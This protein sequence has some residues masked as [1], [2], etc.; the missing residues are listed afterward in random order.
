[1]LLAKPAGYLFSKDEY[2]QH[3]K[4]AKK[5]D[6]SCHGE[7]LNNLADAKTSVCSWNVP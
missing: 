6:A 4:E 2:L 7:T 5:Q 3:T 1:M